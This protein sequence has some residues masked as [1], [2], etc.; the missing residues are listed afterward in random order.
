PAPVS[1]LLLALVVAPYLL[2][3]AALLRAYRAGVGER[4]RQ[5]IVWGLLG[6]TLVTWIAVSLGSVVRLTP[7]WILR[8]LV[9]IPAYHV[10]RVPY[11]PALAWVA[12]LM[13]IAAAYR[14]AERQFARMEIP[15][16]PCKYTLIDCF[17]NDS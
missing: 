7:P 10:G 3:V 6:V 5:S 1:G 16:R 15:A 12:C 11:G 9:E 8:A 14:V 2:A 13:V 4:V 17:A